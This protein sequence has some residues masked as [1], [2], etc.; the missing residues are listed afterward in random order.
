MGW[1]RASAAAGRGPA[2]SGARAA[3]EAS[4]SW[5]RRFLRLPP[6]CPLPHP[7]VEMLE[8]VGAGHDREDDSGRP[9]RARG[10]HQTA[11]VLVR[12]RGAR[13]V[14]QVRSSMSVGLPWAAGESRAPEA[15][16][17]TPALERPRRRVACV[18]P[19]CNRSQP[20]GDATATR[21]GGDTA[22]S[23]CPLRGGLN[24]MPPFASSKHAPD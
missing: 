23:L 13:R 22:S 18:A 8:V 2:A 17:G 7:G 20:P 16:G 10:E 4:A 15:D 12:S 11:D 1:E 3:W 24:N 14:R 5:Q 21:R 19:P 9:C 6:L